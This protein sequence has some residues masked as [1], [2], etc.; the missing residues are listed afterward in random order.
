MK[1]KTL[2]GRLFSFHILLQAHI[3]N[4]LILLT[5]QLMFWMT[6]VGFNFSRI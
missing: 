6:C 2:R 4:F 1:N 5:F 3:G